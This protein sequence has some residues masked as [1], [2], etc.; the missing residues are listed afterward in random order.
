MK[1]VMLVITIFFM[2]ILLLPVGV[3][4]L[5]WAVYVVLVPLGWLSGQP[6][7]PPEFG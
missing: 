1:V 2:G 7:V 5:T 4:V 3:K 6:A